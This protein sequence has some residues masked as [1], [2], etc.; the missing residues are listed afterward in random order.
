MRNLKLS[1]KIGLGFGIVILIACLLGGMAIWNMA[2]ITREAKIL[3]QEYLPEVS[4]FTNIERSSL[5]TM[6]AMRGYAFTMEH[7]YLEEGKTRLEEVKQSIKD[8]Y[9]L[10][11]NAVH[12]T[13]LQKAV[14]KV[15][16]R[17]AE[18]EKFADETVA[19]NRAIEENRNT[20]NDTTQV[21]LENCDVFLDSQQKLMLEEIENGA[22]VL[23]IKERLQ[24]ITLLNHI[25][26]LNNTAQVEILKAQ[27]SRDP[28]LMQGAL[29]NFDELESM[30]IEIEGI[31]RREVNLKQLKNTREAARTYQ[32]TIQ[33]LWQNW[34]ALEAL[35]QQRTAVAQEVLT[36]AE[37]LAISGIEETEQVTRHTVAL[38]SMASRIMSGGLL[39]AVVV[40]TVIAMVIARGI[41]I[42]VQK[43]VEFAKAIA[44]GDLNATVDVDQ[45]DEI[46]ILTNTLQAMRDRIREVLREMDGL[47]RAIQEGKLETRGDT[48]SFSGAWRDLVLGL[49]DVVNVFM[50]P[51]NVAA[52]YIDR[53]S[54]GDLPQQIT[55][56]YQGDFNELKNNLNGLIEGLHGLI[57]VA[58]AIA[59]GDTSVNI[60]T[61]SEHDQ[62]A[63]AFQR[64]NASVTN[65]ILEMN[66]LTE[67]AVAGKLDTRGNTA[68]FQGDFARI[69][70]GVN[71]TLDEVIGPLNVAAEY[72]DRISKGDIPEPITDE[73]QGDFNEI[74]NN[75]NQCIAA[76]NGLV[77][78]T[79]DLIQTATAEQFETRADI[80]RHQGKF[81]EIVQGINKT[82]D[83]VVNKVFWYE[84]LL[85]AV[86]WPVSVTDL[87]MNWTFF[88]KA[89]EEITGLKRSEMLG[90]ACKHWNADIC[91][92]ERCG[93]AMLRK[94]K[95]T[96][97]FTQPG[98]N[99]DF[100]V[101]T[102]YLKNVKGE[103]I[104]HVEIVQDVTTANRV[105]QYQTIEVNRLANNLKRIA[106]GDLTFELTVANGD[107]YT[108]AE[109]ENFLKINESLKRVKDTFLALVE[110]AEKL[111]KAAVQGKLDIRGD[112][113]QFQGDFAK[114]VQGINNT[115]DAVVVPLHVAAEYVDRISKGDIPASITD[116]YQGDF[117]EIKNNLNILIEA[118]NTIVRQAQ[119]MAAGNLL[120]ALQERSSRDQL[121]QALNMMILRLKEVVINVKGATENITASSQAMSQS[122]EEMSQGATEQAAAAEQAS[123]SME[124]MAANIRQNSEN[125]L[126]TEKLALQAAKDAQISGQAV[127]ETVAAM[128]DIAHKVV[129]I[130][131]IARQTRMLS[132]NA[133]IEAARAQDHGRG[134][135][136]VASEVR[137]LAERS[138]AAA[139]E[140]NALVTS[141]VMIAENTG[142]MLTK[143]VPDIQRTAELVQEISAASKEQDAGA[144]QINKA[145]QQLD[146]VIQQ[147]ATVS[148]EMAATSTELASQA[149]QLQESMQFFKTEAY[150][151]TQTPPGEQ[152]TLKP[153]LYLQ[154]AQSSNLRRAQMI[155]EPSPDKAL[156]SKGSVSGNSGSYAIRMDSIAA[157]ED[158][159]DEEFERF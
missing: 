43:G 85:D 123:S 5:E 110:E 158:L 151:E 21:Y 40:A 130:E 36:E 8:A 84:Q 87:D 29:K 129:L 128:K 18:Y 102:A 137:S 144:S 93:I 27:A 34:T 100:Q 135:A 150:D 108:N 52:E 78:A 126:Q 49:N 125:A 95:T 113:T 119:E 71:N 50:T 89:A 98:L 26:K 6:Y 63:V 112:T 32:A 25:I 140:I 15:D 122:S 10:A 12:L 156:K 80:T 17:M 103:Q 86:P 143:L 57:D 92:T 1:L 67:A 148:E 120:I 77:Q 97:Y 121:M 54:K 68:K 127:S 116:E 136:V 16:T 118:T 81:Q 44:Q 24:K 22:P 134:F 94:G 72:V 73:Y 28:R 51:F 91:D 111:T 56:D 69:V 31:T 64:M 107:E 79:D 48:E 96:T 146:Q 3:Q 132:L 101:D 70:Q 2:N 47:S 105:K 154:T 114:I 99:K 106:N 141:S 19:R 62:L 11:E 124:Q 66:T 39:I 9:R 45:H 117:N 30:F 37:N 149:E 145:I 38:L 90:K 115:L 55:D 60:Q 109:R 155:I 41:I 7:S 159:H 74:K 33:D 13:L 75:L 53:I 61:R 20:L 83:V 82:L 23:Q 35:N 153:H 65:L 4:I 142:N 138:Q 139:L 131:D 157:A 133:T 58:N 46:G 42:P 76:I 59:A 88:N 147:N 152:T 14:E 104:G